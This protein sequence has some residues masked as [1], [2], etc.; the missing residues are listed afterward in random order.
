MVNDKHASTCTRPSPG[1]KVTRK[2]AAISCRLSQDRGAH[3]EGLSRVEVDGDSVVADTFG[4]TLAEL[5]A[6]NRFEQRP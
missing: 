6:L 3:P 1:P 4:F 5:T 2:Q